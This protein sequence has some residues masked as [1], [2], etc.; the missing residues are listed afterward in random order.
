NTADAVAPQEGQEVDVRILSTTDLHTNLVN[1]DYY[2]DK[3]SQTIGLA[4]TA[5]LI[6]HA[7]AENSNVI[8][9]DNGDLIQG[10]PLG[11]YKALVDRVEKGEQ[12]PMYAALDALGFDAST[13]GNHE[14]NYGLDYLKNVIST[15]GLPVVNAN[16]I[17]AT[18]NQPLFKQYEIITKT[19]K[20]AGGKQ[21]NLNIGITGIVPP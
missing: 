10:T 14:F 2:Q 1:Y 20:D 21:V 3:A 13:L 17:D 16:V 5:V 6:D 12:H 19:F 8:L 9:V 15:A 7:K 18:S 4:K 11:T